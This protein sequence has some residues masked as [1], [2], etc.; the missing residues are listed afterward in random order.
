MKKL[1][2]VNMA[3]SLKLSGIN[4]SSVKLRGKTVKWKEQVAEGFP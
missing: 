3:A 2:N 4:H 1:D